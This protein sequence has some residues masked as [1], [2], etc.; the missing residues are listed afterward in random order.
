MHIIEFT[1]PM[2]GFEGKFNTFRLGKK[3]SVILK[4]GDRVGLVDKKE[5]YI[6]ALAKVEAILTG[7]FMKWR[8]DT[9]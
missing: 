7:D 6:F 4:Q 3:Y 9:R 5:H 2:Q 1:P 8:C